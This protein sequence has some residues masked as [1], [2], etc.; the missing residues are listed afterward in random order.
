MSGSRTRGTKTS[1]SRASPPRI[2][3][4]GLASAPAADLLGCSLRS[5]LTPHA[6]DF[7]D[8]LQNDLLVI[9][10]DRR[11][12]AAAHLV[13]HLASLAPWM[14][15]ATQILWVIDDSGL[16][17]RRSIEALRPPPWVVADGQLVRRWGAHGFPVIGHVHKDGQIIHV[18]ALRRSEDFGR[19][20][21]SSSSDGLS[22]WI[23]VVHLARN[24]VAQGS[25]QVRRAATEKTVVLW[26]CGSVTGRL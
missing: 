5:A 13:D 26:G 24:Q 11:S 10:A 12:V 2:G 21:F 25:R 8:G 23:S 18:T 7:L 6:A 4:D 17:L 1:N 20:I 22:A 19:F 14:T 9:A 15:T 3:P 16:R